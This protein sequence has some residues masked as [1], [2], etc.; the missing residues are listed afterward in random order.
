MSPF[1]PSISLNSVDN[2]FCTADHCVR[3]SG[4]IHVIIGP[5]FAGK[6]SALLS[7]VKS[8]ETNGRYLRFYSFLLVFYYLSLW[9]ILVDY[10]FCLSKDQ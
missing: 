6:T 4:A 3:G 8:E 2:G 5:M 7:R 9:P 1:N 10:V